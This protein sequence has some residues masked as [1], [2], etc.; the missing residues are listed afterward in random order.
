MFETDKDPETIGA[1]LEQQEAKKTALDLYKRDALDL[2]QAAA[3]TPEDRPEPLRPL[4]RYID[5][6][7]GRAT[8]FL[9]RGTLTMITGQKGCRK[10]TFVRALCSILL[11]GKI[12]SACPHTLTARAGGL[13]LAVVDT[14][15][16]KSRVFRAFEWMQK[17]YKGTEPFA[18][19][20]AFYS[21]RGLDADGLHDLLCTICE[22]TRPD[23]V[24]L[25]V[26][27]H[28][29][30]DINDQRAAKL[31]VDYV[32]QICNEY[33]CAVVGIIH[34]NPNKEATAADK[35]AGA[36]GTKLLQAAECVLH[37]ART[38]EGLQQIDADGQSMGFLF[39]KGSVITFAEYRERWP[40]IL[41]FLI[42][43]ENE[44][45][46]YEL[47]LQP[48]TIKSEGKQG[49]AKTL[50]AFLQPARMVTATAENLQ[51]MEAAAASPLLDLSPEA[52]GWAAE[53]E[54]ATLPAALLDGGTDAEPESGDDLPF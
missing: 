4:L 40:D 19:R 3:L 49:F 15:Q 10:S 34:Q 14:E 33:G 44:K 51:R 43:N 6:S 54:G 29:V 42:Q 1:E 37:V 36:L 2:M 13:R 24:F 45:G 20:C 53:P 11:N 25:D 16:H 48:V 26:I 17:S 52:N 23:V 18:N 47:N 9:C 8:D 38:P 12:Q 22:T 41:T 21:G 50:T 28:F 32:N 30:D 27:S 5:G 35:M 31:M 7:C 39:G 46:E